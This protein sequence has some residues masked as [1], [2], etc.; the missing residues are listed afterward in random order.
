MF[1]AVELPAGISDL[2]TGLTDVDRNALSHFLGKIEEGRETLE[3]R[4]ERKDL[5]DEFFKR[6]LLRRLL[7]VSNCEFCV[8]LLGRLYRRLWHQEENEGGLNLKCA[9]NI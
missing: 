3:G 2:D 4:K 6:R 8:V 7:S 5:N 9:V 1:E